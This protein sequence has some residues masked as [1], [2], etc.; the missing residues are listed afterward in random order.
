MSHFITHKHINH[1]YLR[2]YKA[3]RIITYFQIHPFMQNKANS[4]NDKMS[5]NIDMTSFY[6]ILSRRMGQK[7]N[8]IQTQFKPKQTQF[9]PIQTQFK[10]KFIKVYPRELLTCLAT[11]DQFITLKGAYSNPIFSA[12]PYET[13]IYFRILLHYSAYCVILLHIDERCLICN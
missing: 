6:K 3:L 4:R 5:A 7:T 2:A 1:S 8:P 11:G 13:E 12:T 10:P 9:N